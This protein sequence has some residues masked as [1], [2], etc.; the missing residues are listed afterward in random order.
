MKICII[1]ILRN[2]PEA[3]GM[4][5]FSSAFTTFEVSTSP[6]P[7]LNKISDQ[8]K[9]YAVKVPPISC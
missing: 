4:Q 2:S 8:T 6:L 1:H 3:P 7:V 5:P 9:S